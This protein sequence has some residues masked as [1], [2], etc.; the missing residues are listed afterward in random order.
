MGGERNGLRRI[1]VSPVGRRQ[2]VDLLYRHLLSQR[3]SLDQWQLWLNT[4]DQEDID[5]MRTLAVRHPDWIICR[6]AMVKPDGSSTIYQFFPQCADP[7]CVYL[8][9]DDDIV[10]LQNGFLDEMFNFREVNHEFFLVYGNVIN[11]AITTHL[12]QRRGQLDMRNGFAHY[13]CEDSVGWENPGYAEYVHRSFIDAVNDGSWEEWRF[14]KWILRNFERV[15][16]NCISWLGREFGKFRGDVGKNEEIWLSCEKPESLNIANA[17]NGRA[18]CA[19]F[20]FKPQREH[21]DGTN[22]LEMYEAICPK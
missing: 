20:S 11:N 2:Y 8:R 22:I 18:I 13:N 21:L 7:M 15:S 9:L 14:E 6:D 17:I 10:W 5:Y 16:I 19:H 4:L 3:D 1:V 12:H